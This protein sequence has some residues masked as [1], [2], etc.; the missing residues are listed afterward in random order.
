MPLRTLTRKRSV[1]SLLAYPLIARTVVIGASTCKPARSTATSFC[2]LF[3]SPEYLLYFCRCAS[4]CLIGYR[5]NDIGS[6]QI[7]ASRLGCVTGLGAP[8]NCQHAATSVT[9][10]FTDLA[11][12][13]RLLL[14]SRSKHT[15]VYR[16]TLLYPLYVLSEAAII[17][18]DLAEL[19]GSAIALVLLFPKLP[20]WAGVLITASDVFILLALK[21]PLGGKPVRL[22]EIIIGALVSHLLDPIH[23]Q[24]DILIP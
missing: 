16:W 10:A 4:R 2:L 11:A 1:L 21:D 17:A 8:P 6:A 23:S 18:T 7:L 19:L 9:D 20:L 14:H 12:H 15:L 5:G 3:C 24:S 22:F 13:C